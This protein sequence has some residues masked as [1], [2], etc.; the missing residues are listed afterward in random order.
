MDSDLTLRAGFAGAVH[1]HNSALPCVMRHLVLV[2]QS[3]DSDPIFSIWSSP[4]YT[5]D[6]FEQES[7]VL[8]NLKVRHI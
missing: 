8:Q 5:A 4:G 3:V 6:A 2:V 1:R 7:E